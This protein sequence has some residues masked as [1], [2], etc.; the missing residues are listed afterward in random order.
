MVTKNEKSNQHS[1]KNEY[2]PPTGVEDSR[3]RLNTNV[4]VTVMP[5]L[6]LLAGD[7]RFFAL[8][9]ALLLWYIN[10]PLFTSTIITE[11]LVKNKIDL[12]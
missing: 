9:P 10:L 4:Y 7:L 12:V 2:V 1:A 5:T 11:Y 8:S 3:M 6:P